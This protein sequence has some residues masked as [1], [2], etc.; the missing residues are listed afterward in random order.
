MLQLFLEWYLTKSWIVVRLSKSISGTILL[1]LLPNWYAPSNTNSIRSFSPQNCFILFIFLQPKNAG[2]R[3]PFPSDCFHKLTSFSRLLI[4][5]YLQHY[6]MSFLQTRTMYSCFFLKNLVR[7]IV[8]H[9]ILLNHISS[10][11]MLNQIFL[12]LSLPYRRRD[13]SLETNNGRGS[14][15]DAGENKTSRIS[16]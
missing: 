16:R 11:T 13:G 6:W 15:T 5:N 14:K 7:L 9:L 12:K 3:Y 8:N 2:G 10:T 1:K 4:S